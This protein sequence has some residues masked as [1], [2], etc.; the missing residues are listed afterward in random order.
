MYAVQASVDMDLSM[1]IHVKSVD[2]IDI[3]IDVKFH[4]HDHGNPAYVWII[5]SES[6]VTCRLVTNDCVRLFN[7]KDVIEDEDEESD[8]VDKEEAVKALKDTNKLEERGAAMRGNQQTTNADMTLRVSS[9][10]VDV[11]NNVEKGQSHSHTFTV[12][13]N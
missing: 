13:L 12:V 10:T 5:C 4:I 9:H 8:G 2:N 11:K 7:V 6:Y 3:D 1:D